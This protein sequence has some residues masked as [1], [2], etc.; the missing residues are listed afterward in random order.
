LAANGLGAANYSARCEEI[1]ARY[2]RQRIAAL[3]LAGLFALKD[4]P[5]RAI[6]TLGEVFTSRIEVAD[7]DFLRKYAAVRS[8]P[9]PAGDREVAVPISRDLV[10]MRL[11]QLHTR[12]GEFDW[13]ESAAAEL[14]DTPVAHELR[15]RIA[16]ARQDAVPGDR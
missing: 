5:A 16:A 11:V 9:M 10:G 3:T 2:P 1:A 15:R 7:D 8:F 13:A 4:D 6:R 12:A 14:K